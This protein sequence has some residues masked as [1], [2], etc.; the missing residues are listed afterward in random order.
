MQRTVDYIEMKPQTR[1]LSVTE[2]LLSYILSFLP[3]RDILRCTSVCKTLRQ[4]YLSSSRLQYIVEMSGQK[5]LAVPNTDNSIPISKHL[6]FLRDKAHAWFKVDLHSFKTVPVTMSQYFREKPNIVAGGHFCWWSRQEDTAMIFP[7]LP[8]PSQQ[9]IQRNW[10]PG[11]LCSVPHSRNL[12]VFMDPAQNLIAVAYVV[13]HKAVY[14]NLGALDSDGVHPEAAGERLFL[15]DDSENRSET[16]SAKL[17]GFG[18][19]IA[20]SHR[21]DD[22]NL[23]SLDKAWQLQIWDW[24]YSTTSS[25][26]LSGAVPNRSYTAIDFCFLGNN[27]LLVTTDNLNLYSIEDMSQPPELLAC[28]LMPKLMELRCLSPIDDIGHSSESHMQAQSTMYT[29]DPTH[30]L[31][32]LT[33][34]PTV[35]SLLSST[36]VF[37]I[38]TRIFFDLDG[39]AAATPIPWQHWGPSN[40]RVFHYWHSFQ[41]HINGNR[42][43][44]AFPVDTRAEK[45]QPVLHLMDFS[46]LAVT[47]R[48]GLGRVVKKPSTTYIS[49]SNDEFGE[50]LTTSLPYVE[51]VFSDRKFDSDDS[52]LQDIWIDRDRIYTLNADTERVWF[53]GSPLFQAGSTGKLEVIDV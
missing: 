52:E 51:V 42:V 11:K 39:M 46:P 48:R 41:I 35:G 47:N 44:Q 13:D 40:T 5:L 2:E 28:F 30:Q 20:L 24:K 50:Y 7:V 36:Q 9:S 26:I 25:S 10:L 53:G 37:I 38:S 4:T 18:R 43:L 8:K 33:A 17:K 23:T 22:V 31:I 45:W 34:F 49:D 16:K 29:S 19:H 27:R 32:C 15:S 1:F 3:H 6:Q 21:L 12:D 14:I